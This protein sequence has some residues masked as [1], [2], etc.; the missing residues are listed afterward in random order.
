VGAIERLAK[1]EYII[2]GANQ[3]EPETSRE[4]GEKREKTANTNCVK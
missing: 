2:A 1:L 4:P 3:R